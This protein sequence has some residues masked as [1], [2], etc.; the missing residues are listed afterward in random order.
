MP[1]TVNTALKA[2]LDALQS[3]VTFA[4]AEIPL[5]LK[6]KLAYDFYSTAVELSLVILIAVGLIISFVQFRKYDHKRGAFNDY[7]KEPIGTIVTGVVGGVWLIITITS[8]FHDLDILFKISLA[9]RLYL[10]EWL[11]SIV[12]K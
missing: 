8:L 11:V 9:P 6:E 5:L 3:G 12:K 4:K 7:N 10:M 2:V 1:D